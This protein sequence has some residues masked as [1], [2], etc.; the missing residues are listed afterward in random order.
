[1]PVGVYGE[2]YIGGAGLARGYLKREEMTAERFVPNP[3]SK[4]EGAR[5]YRTGD[6]VRWRA[7]GNLEYEGR[8][9]Q[10]VKV[11][12]YRIELGE[13]EA[14]IGRIGGVRQ[15]AVIVREDEIGDR[16][17][18]AYVVGEERVSISEMRAQLQGRLPEYMM[19]TAF[20]QM[21]ELPQT[22]NGKLDRKALPKPE[23]VQSGA[24][25]LAPRDNI[26]THLKAI[27]EEILGI[28]DI[29][30]RDNFFELG[31]HSLKA[32]AI[33]SRVAKMYETSFPVRMIFDC[34]TIEGQA[35]Y[36]R[37]EVSLTPP[38]SIIPIQRKGSLPP[39]FCVHPVGGLV[40][41]YVSLARHLGT[42]QPFYGIQSLGMEN[43]HAPDVTI[44]A[45]ATSYVAEMKTIKPTGPYQIA[46]YSMGAAIAYEMATQLMNAGE[47][48]SLLAL[49]D[50]GF[51]SLPQN[52]PSIEWEEGLVE[53]EQNM[54]DGLA[55]EH[56]NEAAEALRPLPFE[57][58]ISGYL[59]AAKTLDLIPGDINLTQFRRLLRV[60][61]TNELAQKRYRPQPYPG[62]VTLFRTPVGEGADPYY[63][64]ADIVMGG[65]EVHEVPGTHL[66]FVTE[67]S[68]Q[69]LAEKLKACIPTQ[70]SA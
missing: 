30:I 59:A 2:L 40:N 51:S 38:S 10:Q 33:S 6:K 15:A 17:L 62:T 49:L 11:R 64:L 9:D 41:C 32:V 26:E 12:G 53:V 54:L 57:E 66:K 18:V 20:V 7:D 44:E 3:Y 67:P 52:E 8:L 5:L 34:P 16:R 63:G 58:R 27:W 68:V 28:E 60:M 50:G 25:V 36:L 47:E 13:I 35:A 24:T 19:P 56:L 31:G 21:E 42:D 14:I 55:A 43:G 37:Q 22:P 23:L 39:I 45:M 70:E 46:G 1:V 61:A 69:I 48:V 29:G 65:V 4:E